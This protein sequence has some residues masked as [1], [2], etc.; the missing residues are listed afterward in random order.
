MALELDDVAVSARIAAACESMRLPCSPAQRAQ[1]C[2]YIREMQK[3]NRTYNLTALRDPAQMLVQHIFDSLA[4]IVPLTRMLGGAHVQASLCDIGSGGGL[5]GVVFAV[6]NPHW[7]VQC[8][9]AVEKKTAFVRQMVGALSLDNLQAT[10]SRVEQL[11]PQQA[12]IVVSRAF[13][14]L[15]DFATWSG[16]HVADGGLLVAMKGKIPDDEIDVLHA[17]SAWRVESVEALVV[18]ELDA[19]RC[20][21]WMRRNKG[22]P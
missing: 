22:N 15:I 3:W 6:M 8:I 19:Q 2:R 4:P 17:T 13:A 9:D 10:H 14:S 20:L 1:L 11:E 12:D 5:P 7:K 21:V 16:K 18:P